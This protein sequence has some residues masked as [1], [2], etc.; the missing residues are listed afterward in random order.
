MIALCHTAILAVLVLLLRQPPNVSQKNGRLEAGGSKAGQA[1]RPDLSSYYRNRL[2]DVAPGEFDFEVT[3]LRGQGKAPLSLDRVTESIEWVDE[4]AV[5]QGSIVFRR[6]GGPDSLPVGSGHRVRLRVRWAG[7]WYELWTMRVSMP[8]VDKGEGS[9]SVDL[10]DDLDLLR[11]DERDW[12]FRKSKR[13]PNGYSPEAVT[14]DVCRQLGVKVRTVP[15][16]TVR[17]KNLKR[18]DTSGLNIIRKVW[19]EEREKSGRRFVIRMRN[20]ELEVVPY[21][22]NRILYVLQ[23]AITEALLRQEGSARP[24]TVIEAKG[25]IGKGKRAGPVKVT[26]FDAAV[27]RRFGRATRVRDFG[28]VDSKAELERKAKRALAKAIRVKDTATLTF[29]GIPF[30]RRGEGVEVRM[31]A[32]GYGGAKA[33][34]FTTRVSHSLTADGYDT[35]IEVERDDPF[36]KY[37]EAREAAAREKKAKERAKARNG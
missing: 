31:P 9:V 12:N 21:R 6:P 24:V 15:T 20:G 35:T 1:R 7:R 3:L 8:E 26:V 17:I 5:L 2:P 14:R 33:F 13:R 34:V 16:G 37:R 19:A 36:E 29:P 28:R 18:R 32:E 4:E 27:V 22:R 30:I 25:T 23:D 10:L 11:R